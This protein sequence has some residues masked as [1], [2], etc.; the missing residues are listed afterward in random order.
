MEKG[1]YRTGLCQLPRLRAH[2]HRF[3]WLP[4]DGGDA[5]EYQAHIEV[6]FCDASNCTHERVSFTDAGRRRRRATSVVA[7][8]AFAAATVLQAVVATAPANAVQ[9]VPGAGFRVTAGDLSFILKQIKIAERHSATL[10][11]A[12]RAGGGRSTDPATSSLIVG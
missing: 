4:Q 10:T 11:R 5:Q 9:A 8:L 3:P 2:F 12:T 1:P 6:G 7:T